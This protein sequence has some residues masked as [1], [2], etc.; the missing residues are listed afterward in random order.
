ME[1][2]CGCKEMMWMMKNNRVF[3][4]QGGRWFL[5]WT[6][7]DK[8]KKAINIEQFGV[9]IHHCMFCGSKIHNS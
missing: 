8:D 4:K 6:E 3:D 1:Y 7:L 5:T 9:V 2:P